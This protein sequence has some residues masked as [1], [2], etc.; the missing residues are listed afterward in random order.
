MKTR[1][2]FVSNSSS[3]S[4]IVEV[5]TMD[6]SN[7]EFEFILSPDKIEA[8]DSFGFRLIN[9]SCVE[10]YHNYPSNSNPDSDVYKQRDDYADDYRSNMGYHV[11]CN[12][13]EVLY[14]LF[15]H[16]IKFNAVVHYENESIIYDGGDYFYRIQNYGK[17]LSMYHKNDSYEQMCV[18]VMRTKPI[19]RCYVDLYLQQFS[20]EMIDDINGV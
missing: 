14:F 13:D 11:S 17:T 16:R 4:F 18:Q 1:Q 20:D 6:Y 5:K 3:S 2:G 8:L 12:E 10:H 9:C 7:G 15:K 19:E